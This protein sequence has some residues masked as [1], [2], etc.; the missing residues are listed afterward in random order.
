M[1]ILMAEHT[2]FDALMPVGC[3]HIARGL[4]KRG[5]KVTYISTCV[6]PFHLGNLFG[7]KN[8]ETQKRFSNWTVGGEEQGNGIVSYVPLSIL[9]FR[10]NPL[11]DNRFAARNHCL[12]TLPSLTGWIKQH[13]PHDAFLIGDPRF[14]PLV[15]KLKIPLN[16][17]RLT[18]NLMGFEDV[19]RSMKTLLELGREKCG[20]LV[21]TSKPLGDLMEKD[22]GFK[23]ISYVPNGVDFE[24][25]SEDSN[26]VPEDLK[27]IP[28]PRAVYVGAIDH[29][30]DRDLMLSLARKLPKVS[31][32]LI[33][34]PRID[35]SVLQ[36]VSNI[37]ILG[38]RPYGTIPAYLSAC[39]VGIIPF[40][41]NE[42][43]RSV[44]PLKLYEY[45]ACGLP[46]VSTEW[47]EVKALGSPA[48][49]A[50][51][52]DS[53]AVGLEKVLGGNK[54]RKEFQDFAKANSWDDRVDKILG[55][56]AGKKS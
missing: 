4:A 44:S 33:G 15:D 10:R 47:E 42:L 22:Y 29:W 13:G 49:L 50:K 9:P 23:N 16:I 39:Q 55:V 17:L 3:H 51:D 31:F 8:G 32:I 48:I 45:M 53:F 41:N 56:I 18:D 35:L 38:S 54:S 27:N 11:L 5:H 7:S 26:D 40:Q 21:V 52:P 28:E 43:I 25:F 24:R 2:H 1:N 20:Q 36:K 19:P 46:V 14:V 34:P 12:W 6:T 37:H 30:F